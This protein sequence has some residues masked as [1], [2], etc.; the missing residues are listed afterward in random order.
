DLLD[1]SPDLGF[2]PGF[3]VSEIQRIA[4]VG[5]IGRSQAGKFT[6]AFRTEPRQ[7]FGTRSGSRELQTMHA[8][9]QFTIAA[10]YTL[11]SGCFDAGFDAGHSIH[12]PRQR[13]AVG[14]QM[15]VEIA[16]V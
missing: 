7:P 4:A 9:A 10:V 15:R 11:D 14:L 2:E 6:G 12:R 8:K 16:A 5:R 13:T 1:V 3:R